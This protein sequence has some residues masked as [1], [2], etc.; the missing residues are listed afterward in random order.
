MAPE[1]SLVGHRS[2]QVAAATSV[3]DNKASAAHGYGGGGYAITAYDDECCP[4]VID[5]FTLFAILGLIAGGAAALAGLFQQLFG[6]GKRKRR[7]FSPL[8]A[9]LESFG[10]NY[11]N[12]IEN[13]YSGGKGLGYCMMYKC[14]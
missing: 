12:T 9:G 1:V 5:P 3:L 10:L 6:G 13:V 14:S 4:P 8:E 2:G 7:S 11:V